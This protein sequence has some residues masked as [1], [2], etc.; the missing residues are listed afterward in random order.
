[1]LRRP[2]DHLLPVSRN[3]F[4]RNAAQQIRI[5]RKIDSQQRQGAAANSQRRAL[6]GV[7]AL[8]GHRQI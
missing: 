6:A 4:S 7:L 8:T 2:Q 1:M 3:P 5:K